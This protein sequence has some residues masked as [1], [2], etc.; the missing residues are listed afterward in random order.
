MF[1][2]D[3]AV[4][5]RGRFAGRVR[6]YPRVADDGL[7]QI[8]FVCFD[9]IRVTGLHAVRMFIISAP[10]AGVLLAGSLP[11]TLVAAKPQTA[12]PCQFA[13]TPEKDWRSWWFTKNELKAAVAGQPESPT[14]RGRWGLTHC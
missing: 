1:F 6:D 7:S 13:N 12:E 10:L 5:V 11:D 4:I 8:A 14:T 3:R 9:G 2:D